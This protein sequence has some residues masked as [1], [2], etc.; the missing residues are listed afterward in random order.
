LH[1]AS[2]SDPQAASGS[3]LPSARE[4]AEF[5]LPAQHPLTRSWVDDDLR[6][7]L[8]TKQHELDI[9]L[10]TDPEIAALRTERFAP[11]RP[12]EVMF[13]QWVQLAA[14]Q[15][16]MLSMRYDDGDRTKPF[17]DASALSRSLQQED[18][19]PAAS[20]ASQ[21]FGSLNPKY[22]R[23][24]SSEPT[25]FFPETLPDRRFLA[26]PLAILR[27]AG[28]SVPPELTLVRATSLA[29]YEL[30]Q[31]AYDAVDAAHPDHPQQAQL[32]RRDKL[33]STI[34][35]GFLFDITV[36]GRWAGYIAAKPDG[37]DLGLPAYT[38][39]DIILSPTHRARGYGPHLTTLLARG[40]PDD[41]P[42]LIGTI[43]ANNRG[44]LTAALTS[45]RADIGGW[46]QIPLPGVQG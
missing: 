5:S 15:H 18:L 34:E 9:E 46:L 40:L 12:I 22:L 11:G 28:E 6:L 42:F 2:P 31:A 3:R 44:A 19:L 7:E 20:A 37:Q 45:G 1:A 8:L 30:A 17:V 38:V 29:N 33:E 16:V 24:W 41:L 39:Q 43:H 14:D 4:L 27:R 10:L 36:D 35:D 23:L 26:G 13:N 32:Q 21:Y 25:G